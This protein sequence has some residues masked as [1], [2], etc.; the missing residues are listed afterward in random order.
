MG[1]VT[2]C[3]LSVLTGLIEVVFFVFSPVKDTVVT[4]DR[5]G[6]GTECHHGGYFTCRDNYD[7]GTEFT[8]QCAVY[9]FI[10]RLTLVHLRVCY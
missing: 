6:T 9:A 10:F 1:H 5:W 3:T 8:V 4:N 7:P 2:Q